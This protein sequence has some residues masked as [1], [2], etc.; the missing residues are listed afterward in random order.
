VRVLA[1]PKLNATGSTR[2]AAASYLYRLQG[3]LIQ[4]YTPALLETHSGQRWCTC[5]LAA[6]RR[7]FRAALEVGLLLTR[8]LRRGVRRIWNRLR[9]HCCYSFNFGGICLTRLEICEFSSLSSFSE[10]SYGDPADSFAQSVA[11][12]RSSD[13]TR[14][15][16]PWSLNSTAL[17]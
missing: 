12:R 13:V 2:G 7:W 10:F 17:S 3:N 8:H 4:M 15:P 5:P 14:G 1:I 11:P 6:S 16:G 9:V